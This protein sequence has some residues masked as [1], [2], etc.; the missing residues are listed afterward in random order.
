MTTVLIVDDHQLIR[1]GL[2]R[3]FERAGGFEVVGEAASVADGLAAVAESDPDVVVTD[4]RMPDGTGLELTR[5]LR[6]SRP[7]LGIVVL[8]MYAGDDVL[9]E[10]M[11][12]GASALVSKE[13]PA[14]D[15]VSAARQAA[16]SPRSFTAKDLAGAMFRRRENKAPRLSERELEVLEL[17]ADGKGVS[18]IARRLFISESTAKTHV[19]RIYDK[20]GAANR[21]Q[22]VLLAVRTGLLSGVQ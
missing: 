5:E 12:S 8:T 2:R 15:V 6:Q 10:A 17:L 18:V 21:A 14:D 16:V 13:A 3:A 19:S 7:Q 22:A 11:D 1:D 4:L 9:F 20:L